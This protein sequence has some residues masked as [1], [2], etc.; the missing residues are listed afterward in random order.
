MWWVSVHTE[1]YALEVITGSRGAGL[2]L[3]VLTDCGFHDILA[4][5]GLFSY[6]EM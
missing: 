3:H 6:V 1:V 2:P 5:F 4:G